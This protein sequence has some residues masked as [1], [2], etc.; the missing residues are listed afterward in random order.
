MQGKG[1]KIDYRRQRTEDP[2]SLSELR[3]GKQMTEDRRQ[4]T[5][6]GVQNSEGSSI[7][8]R[9]RRRNMV[10]GFRCQVSGTRDLLNLKEA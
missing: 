7:A 2:S 10:S 5:D 6:D 1:Q 3:R 8:L 9:P 4:I